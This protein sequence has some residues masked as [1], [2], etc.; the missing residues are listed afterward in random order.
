MPL[1]DFKC[2]CG[3]VLERFEK[4]STEEIQCEC[5]KTAKRQI[6][7]PHA[8]FKGEGFYETDYKR[9]TGTE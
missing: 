6:G 2:E 7:A 3:K 5:G 1:Y 8:I 9:K 4:M